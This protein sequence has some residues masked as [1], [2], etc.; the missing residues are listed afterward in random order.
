[1][2]MN[3]RS[4]VRSAA[5]LAAG[6]A[7]GLG[8]M[9]MLNAFAQSA[10]SS[11]VGDDYKA[12]VC[13]FLSGGNDA[14]NMI[15]P[16]DRD[17]YAGYA[18]ARGSMA[19]AQASLLPS[20]AMPGFALHPSLGG[21]RSLIDSGAAAAVVNVGTLVQPLT[22]AQY[23]SGGAA[24]WNLFS[25]LDQQQEWQNAGS[26]SELHSG[27]AGRIADGLSRVYNPNASIPMI[28]SL[29]GDAL[30][31]DGVSTS[32]LTVNPGQLGTGT[33]S[34][35]DL[36]A[37]RAAAQQ[38]LLSFDSGISLVQADHR[39]TTDAFRYAAALAGAA[40]SVQPMQTKFPANG[41][42]K[43]LQ[44][45][46][47]ILQIRAAL[48]VSRQIFFCNLGSFDTHGGQLE[49]QALLLQ[50]L[51]DALVAFQEATVELGLTKNVT[52]FTM[53]EFSRTL[54]PNS[55]DGTDHAWGSHHLVVGGAV[56]GGA[57]YGNFPT[58]AL[59]GPDDSGGNGRWIP[60]T[61]SS[62]YGATLAKWFG[63]GASQMGTIFPTLAGFSTT[64]LGFL[65]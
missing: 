49:M 6:N 28:T 57:M 39:I 29:S 53:S 47:Q 35:G 2:Q 60:T 56:K 26:S 65:A 27:W 1:M 24:P 46:A 15:V 18:A 40:Q 52:T 25:H 59:G 45:V 3:R 42:A 62:Q 13:I 16:F 17:G 37:T 55:V 34:A 61:A 51:N 21:V 30:L 33:C 31:C 14:N 36:C 11:G 43:Q 50:N 48:G 32:A 41:I 58:L 23:L 4:F 8:S 64:D 12:L 10:T 7:A 19:L 22:R 63:V 44:Q 5:L 20:A 9:G 54:Q 38:A